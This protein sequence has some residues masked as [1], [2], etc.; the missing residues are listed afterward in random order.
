MLPLSDNLFLIQSSSAGEGKTR[1]MAK[2]LILCHQDGKFSG[3]SAGFGLPVLRTIN[4][5]I[6]P[7]LFSTTIH[8]SGSVEAVYHLNLINTWQ[9]AG[10]AGSSSVFG[11]YG[12][13]REFLYGPSKISINRFNNSKY[14]F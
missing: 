9:I 4:Q 12:K 14:P 13:N 1:K 7:S 8:K 6:F 10:I 11:F 3:E 5:T 2:G